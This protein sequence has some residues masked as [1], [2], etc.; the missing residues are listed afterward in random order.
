MD[1]RQRIMKSIRWLLGV[2]L[3]VV[4]L[5]TTW[6]WGVVARLA[7]PA[8]AAEQLP[9]TA[10]YAAWQRDGSEQPTL[11]RSM[12][13]GVTWMP[14]TLSVGVAP[15]VWADDGSQG[16]AVATDDGTVL[17][18]GDLG[19]TWTVMAEG[20]PVSSLIWDDDGGLYLGTSGRGIYRL[21]ADGTLLETTMMHGELA[22]ADIVDLSLT[23]G[24]LF[25]A[26]PAVLFYTA[27]RGA[28]W[29]KTTPLPEGVTAIAAAD[30]QTVYAGT[31]TSGVYKSSDAGR[32][33]L[34]AWEGLGLAA[35]QMVK[36]TALRADPSE[37]GVLYVAVDHV[38][39]STQVHASAAGLFATVDGGASWQPLA[40]P[41]FPEARHASS[42]ILTP[43]KPLHARAVTAEGPQAYAPD[44]MRLRAALESD[45]PRM[46]A[47]AA[48]QLGMA[49]PLGV[50][51]ELLPALDDPDP[52]V[53]LIAAD[54]L[55]RINDPAAVPGLLIAVE[56]PSEQVRLGAAR[57][58]GM[59]GIEAAVEPLRAMLL[60]AEGLEVGVA[61]EALGRIG[62]PVAAEALLTA[63]ADP[64]P[65]ARWHVA[66]AAL[67][68]MGEPAV[69]PLV[70]ML[71]SQD[72]LIR[73]NAAQALGWIGSSSATEALVHALKNDHDTT[74][75]G[76]A[77][78]ALGEIGDPAARRT[79]ER[80]QLRDS[81]VEVQT[82]AGRALSRV[83][84]GSE[85]ATGWATRWAPALNQLQPVRW[86]VLGLSLIGGAWLMMGR[87]A[88]AAVPLRLRHRHR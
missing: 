22:A 76:Q 74:V 25:A 32:T 47:S 73:R 26:T 85:A 10:L 39:G 59:M 68:R 79:L 7:G 17:R 67:E 63:L 62:G 31:A 81:A 9:V 18:S 4:G 86:L 46:R 78:W 1:M 57:A 44:V 56:H 3:V 35:G 12:D 84:A 37:P 36:V 82:A 54:A 34:P 6:A 28:T 75:R 80:A 16:V 14:L 60:Q 51:N 11:F 77:A 64:Q 5:S 30:P 55:G 61:G 24:H 72:A 48:R 83:P 23:E 2:L 29:T 87:G 40:G 19:G 52:T 8:P 41:S 50:W 58:L 13:E 69:E 43:G 15:R 71:D 21:A 38:V 49:R 33:W 27:D 88:L 53:R 45:D 65:T 42:L 66:M 20:L 70:A